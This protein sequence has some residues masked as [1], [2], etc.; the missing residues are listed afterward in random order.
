MNKK[1][2]IAHVQAPLLDTL[3]YYLYTVL[4]IYCTNT[5]HV[6]AHLLDTR[7]G[8][9]ARACP[10]KRHSHCQRHAIMGIGIV[11]RDR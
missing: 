2:C 10:P 5:M 9:Q 6:Q 3:L 4:L 11:M 8:Q 7:L 1:V